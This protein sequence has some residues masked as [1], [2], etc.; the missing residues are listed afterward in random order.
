[1][2]SGDK[3]R[4]ILDFVRQQA[5]IFLLLLDKKGTIVDTN[6]YTLE[7]VGEALRSKTIWDIFLDFSHSLDLSQLTQDPDEKKADECEN[8]NRTAANLLYPIH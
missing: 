6:A 4:I 7:L 2:I 5:P 8:V 3:D 1:M